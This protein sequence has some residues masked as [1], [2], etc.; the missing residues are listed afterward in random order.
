MGRQA[1]LGNRNA[2]AQ[3]TLGQASGGR[4]MPFAG[5]QAGPVA[6]AQGG[7]GSPAPPTNQVPGAQFRGPQMTTLGGMKPFQAGGQSMM[8]Q[9]GGGM[10]GMNAG[11]YGYHPAIQGLMGQ[12]NPGMQSVLQSRLGQMGMGGGGMAGGNM[13]AYAQQPQMQQP[14]Y[15]QPM[16]GGNM[17]PYAQQ[18]QQSPGMWQP[19]MRLS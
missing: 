17:S 9:F 2:N 13:G 1:M 3:M 16:A 10:Q 5:R 6:M 14:Q 19:G 12:V 11:G 18:P 15:R 4:P 8:P 7:G